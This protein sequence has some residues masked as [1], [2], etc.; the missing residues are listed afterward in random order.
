MAAGKQVAG[1]AWPPKEEFADRLA[2]LRRARPMSNAEI[3]AACQINPNTVS[4]WN[5]GQTPQGMVL[6]RLAKLFDVS[7]E[8]LLEGDEATEEIKTPVA[9]RGRKVSRGTQTKNPRK[10]RGA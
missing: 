4:N 2:R 9:P 10:D 8:W 5:S 1:A 6:I 7:P 3:A